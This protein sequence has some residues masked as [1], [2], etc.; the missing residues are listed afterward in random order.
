MTRN[1]RHA[2]AGVSPSE[3]SISR[4][5]LQHR[6]IGEVQM[7]RWHRMIRFRSRLLV[8]LAGAGI[9]AIAH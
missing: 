5:V 4:A 1:G 7:I 2:L 3:L 6:C 9:L 8:H